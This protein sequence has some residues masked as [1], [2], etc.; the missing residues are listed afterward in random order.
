MSYLEAIRNGDIADMTYYLARGADPNT[1]FATNVKA[2]YGIN[3]SAVME[4][5][6]TDH[7]DCVRL[8]LDHGAKLDAIDSKGWTALMIA[9]ANG[10]SDLV[11]LLLER[12]ASLQ[13]KNK[14]G[15]TA[16]MLAERYNRSELIT[17]LKQAGARE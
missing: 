1:T 17:L 16:L 11:H 4:A 6:A 3:A 9:T 13:S 8:L 2:A 10:D 15:K 14:T 12:G 5:A 7:I